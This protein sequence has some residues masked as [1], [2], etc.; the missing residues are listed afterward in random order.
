MYKADSVCLKFCKN[1]FRYLYDAYEE[2]YSDM[3]IDEITMDYAFL[4]I[5]FIRKTKF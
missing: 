2:M 3:L 1:P 5:D 4:H